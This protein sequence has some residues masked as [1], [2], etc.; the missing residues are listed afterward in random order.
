MSTSSILF[1]ATE[2]YL[3]AM[4][5]HGHT[6]AD[7]HTAI[8]RVA[9]GMLTGFLTPRE[10]EIMKLLAL[11]DTVRAIAIKLNIS[12]KTVEV[13]KANLMRKLNIHSKV[14]LVHMAIAQKLISISIHNEDTNT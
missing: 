13:H 4:S 12:I 1:T 3:I 11:G 14:E 5:K 10:L 8:S 7:C 6:P 2:K 9:S